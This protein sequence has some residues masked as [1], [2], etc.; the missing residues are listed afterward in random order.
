MSSTNTETHVAALPRLHAADD[1][2]LT[3]CR[4]CG[5]SIWMLV[6]ADTGKRA[7]ID[8][9]PNDTG[10]VVIVDDSFMHDG[11]LRLHHRYHVLHKHDTAD[12]LRFT[13]HFQTCAQASRFG[14]K[15]HRGR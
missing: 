15:S 7:P 14:H 4:G 3:I 10:N 12:G 9:A 6:N 11:E 13:N 5:A 1:R 2:Y 8:T